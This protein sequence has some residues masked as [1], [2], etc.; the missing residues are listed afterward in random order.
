MNTASTVFHFITEWSPVVEPSE[1]VSML[2]TTLAERDEM[3]KR[4]SGQ[5]P[6]AF[7]SQPIG[8]CMVATLAWTRVDFTMP[9]WTF[10]G[11]TKLVWTATSKESR[12]EERAVVTLF[13]YFLFLYRLQRWK[14][15]W[16][17]ARLSLWWS[18]MMCYN[19]WL[20]ALF[21][22]T[23]YLNQ[24]AFGHFICWFM[25][26]FFFFSPFLSPSAFLLVYISNFVLWRH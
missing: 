23:F 19:N 26:R 10:L 22:R 15:Q 16:F 24:Q 17:T 8:F 20:K 14:H 21:V 11:G 5:W 4:G 2:A 7:G 13:F 25:R 9:G 6:L 12:R 18:F 3:D 1:L